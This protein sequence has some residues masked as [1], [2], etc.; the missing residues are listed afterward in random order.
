VIFHLANAQ[1]GYTGA[2]PKAAWD[3]TTG[4]VLDR[5]L[6]HTGPA[7]ASA[8]AT[9]NDSIATNLWDMLGMVFISDPMTAGGALGGLAYVL[10]YGASEA[11][12]GANCV[13]YTHLWV[14]TGDTNVARGTLIANRIGSTE[15]PTTASGRNVAANFD[16]GVTAQ[17]GDRLVLEIGTEFQNT[18]TTSWNA[19]FYYGATGAT[20]LA[21]GST[22]VTTNPGVIDVTGIDSF[23]A[24]PPRPPQTFIHTRPAL[25]RANHW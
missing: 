5:R 9:V 25:I 15:F 2:T 23:F 14:T 1:A 20:N 19:V 22:A 3:S 18:A 10:N 6:S 13:T 16:A 8:T 4:A 7:G 11:A 12:A 24:A 21:S 17:A